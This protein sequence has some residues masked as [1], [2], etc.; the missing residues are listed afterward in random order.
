[1]VFLQMIKTNV[2]IDLQ[3]YHNYR[4]V[5]QEIVENLYNQV[6]DKRINQFCNE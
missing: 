1:M 2:D 4:Q 6:A 3:V 5:S